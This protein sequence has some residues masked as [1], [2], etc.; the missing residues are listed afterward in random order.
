M[1]GPLSD[2]PSGL[3][4]KFAGAKSQ[5]QCF[6][7]PGF[8]RKSVRGTNG[9]VSYEG[10]SCPQATYNVGGNTAGCQK[11]GAGLTTAATQSSAP[12]DCSEY[13]WCLD[14]LLLS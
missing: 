8:G 2:C 7:K 1:V 13:L 5:A 4:S 6:T 10:V 11:C 9:V 14:L 3:E 12:G